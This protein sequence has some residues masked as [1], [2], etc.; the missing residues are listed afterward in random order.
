[1][2]EN[3]EKKINGWKILRFKK[4]NTVIEGVCKNY[5]PYTNISINKN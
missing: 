5:F 4:P 2:T 3:I 1:M